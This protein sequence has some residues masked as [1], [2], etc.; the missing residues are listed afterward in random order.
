MVDLVLIEERVE[1]AF[2]P[3]DGIISDGTGKR[4]FED[5][6]KATIIEGFVRIDSVVPLRS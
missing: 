6:V 5:Q 3:S 1:Y 4:R 2:E